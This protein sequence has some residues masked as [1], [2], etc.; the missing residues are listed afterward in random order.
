MTRS[1]KKRQQ[2]SYGEEDDDEWWSNDT[3]YE[4][5]WHEEEEEL[6]EELESAA[7]QVKSELCGLQAEDEGIGA[8]QRILSG[9]GN[10]T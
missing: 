1:W 8:V 6:L 2:E 10:W 5:G 9:D 7:D 4:E 3:F